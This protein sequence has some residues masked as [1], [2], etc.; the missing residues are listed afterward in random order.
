MFSAFFKIWASLTSSKAKKERKEENKILKSEKERKIFKKKPHKKSPLKS[1]NDPK[2]VEEAKK[3]KKS[4]RLK[5]KA[6]ILNTF[7]AVMH[8]IEWLITIICT[9]IMS[10]LILC[11]IIFFACILI[12]ASQ[13][14]NDN[15]TCKPVGLNGTGG[16]SSVLPSGVS[17]EVKVYKYFKDKGWDDVHIF[18]IMGCLHGES[19]GFESGR[20]QG[21]VGN[22]TSDSKD[23]TAKVNEA[24]KTGDVSAFTEYNGY[25]I[26]QWTSE[27]RKVNLF[28]FAKE[29]GANIDDLSMQL[30]FLMHE[31]ENHSDL[32]YE[33]FKKASS[34][35]DCIA[36]LIDK[37][38]RPGDRAGAKRVR[39]GYANDFMAKKSEY[40]NKIG[41]I[42][43]GN[44]TGDLI[45]AEANKYLG[46]PYLW[47]GTT[48]DGF[49]C[50]GFVQYVMKQVGIS[51]SRTTDTQ[52]N[53]GTAI[54]EANLQPGDIVLFQKSGESTPSHVGIYIGNDEY[55]HSPQANDKVKISKLQARRDNNQTIICRRVVSADEVKKPDTNVTG[56]TVESS[57]TGSFPKYALSDEQKHYIAQIVAREQ[58]SKK[59]YYAEASL[60]A[61]LTDFRGDENATPAKMIAKVNSGWFGPVNNGKVQMGKTCDNAE[62]LQAVEDV[63]IQGRRTLPRYINEHDY[64]G[65]ITQ[66]EN[67]EKDNRASWQPNVSKWFAGKSGKVWITFYEWPDGVE[68]NG[69]PFG[70]DAE[71]EKFKTTYGDFRYTVDGASQGSQG[72]GNT[73]SVSVN[74]PEGYFYKN[75]VL[76][77]IDPNCPIHGNKKGGN[78]DGTSGLVNGIMPRKFN[79]AQPGQIQGNW[80]EDTKAQMMQVGWSEYFGTCW[81]W[82]ENNRNTEKTSGMTWEQWRMDTKW[83]VPY[84]RQNAATEYG[85][86][87][88]QVGG[89]NVRNS[90][91]VF[92]SAYMASALTG[93]MINWPE[94]FAALKVTGGITGGGSF[95]NAGAY[96][97]F[98]Q[99]EIAWVGLKADG[100]IVNSGTQHSELFEGL[101]GSIQDKVNAVLDANGVV[102]ISV[103]GG[104]GKSK[105][106][107]QGHYFSIIA[108]EGNDK[109]KVHSASHHALDSG[110]V[111]W[112]EL[113]GNNGSY[114]RPMADGSAFF[115]A[116]Y[117]GAGLQSGDG[118]TGVA[119]MDGTVESLISNRAEARKGNPY[120]IPTG[121]GGPG[122]LPQVKGITIHYTGHEGGEGKA[123]TVATYIDWYKTRHGANSEAMAHFY[124]DANSGFQAVGDDV[125][126]WHAGNSEWN[127]VSLGIEMCCKQMTANKHTPYRFQKGT[128]IRAVALTRALMKEYNLTDVDACVVRHF[129]KAKDHKLCPEMWINTRSST[130]PTPHPAW[131]AFK[132]AVKTGQIDWGKMEGTYYE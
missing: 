120:G 12:I 32:G 15:C 98:N 90:C 132:E 89:V 75:G 129:D 109:Y 119:D 68:G 84:Y 3:H 71:G 62:A 6:R 116:R 110:W 48:P 59:G 66:V 60:I 46:T 49:D 9:F 82:D 93:K 38:E 27:G 108:H 130:E 70:Y 104:P 13:L 95:C 2:K 44:A 7:A 26:A 112:E 25:G 121:H 55:I 74:A 11:A 100:T 34:I 53:D 107:S 80:S 30:D 79:E 103:V 43:S 57:S 29:R 61:N 72:S 127:G 37:F 52:V 83:E 117:Y 50:S 1:S 123:D 58:G 77:K 19:G 118:I 14:M 81:A 10:H 94:M 88:V 63:I 92:M 56:S 18:S 86:D 125:K 96:K 131:V 17:N 64:I 85:A 67:C 126:A 42:S 105:F 115:L 8:F 20:R 28:N 31:L 114:L 106:A 51:V 33:E 47:G 113:Y 16:A 97:T 5:V 99:L 87:K 73:D 21:D 22:L 40:E 128:I 122:S 65:D 76:Y 102:G 78:S 41:S 91:H 4:R 36:V 35:T 23:F 39:A 124:I 24:L 111:S 101:S 45:V 54:E 69:D